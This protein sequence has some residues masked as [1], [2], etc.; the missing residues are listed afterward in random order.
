[1]GHAHKGF[2][3]FL[4]RGMRWCTTTSGVRL[5]AIAAIAQCLQI[6][7]CVEATF[8]NWFDMVY[9]QYGPFGGAYATRNTSK[10]IAF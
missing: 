2:S 4:A 3:L 10:V 8:G 7:D 6:V 5:S 1:M 9:F